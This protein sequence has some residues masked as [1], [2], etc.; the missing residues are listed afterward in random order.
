MRR[1]G[2]A[3]SFKKIGQGLKRSY[4]KTFCVNPPSPH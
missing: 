3:D 1:L 4:L 2:L